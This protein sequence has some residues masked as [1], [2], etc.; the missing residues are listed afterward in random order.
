MKKRL[1][2]SIPSEIKVG[3][4]VIEL[5]I[6]D[7][8]FLGLGK[9]AVRGT[10]LRSA[11]VPLRPEIQTPDGIR[12]DAFRLDAVRYQRGAVVLLTTAFGRQ[13]MFG[14]YRDEYDSLLA[15][16]RTEGGPFA[17]V[18]EWRLRPETLTLDDTAY[19]GFSYSLRFR[20]KKRSIHQVLMVATWELGGRA[21]GNTLLNQ[22]QVNPPVYT[23]KQSTA[24]T[25]ACWRQLGE[26]GKPDGYSFQFSSRYSPIQCFDFQYGSAG[27]LFG[28][29]PDFVDA[30]S[31]M[32]KNPGEDVVFVLDKYLMPLSRDVAF[33]RKCILWA[34]PPAEGVKEHLMHDR[35]LRAFDHAQGRVRAAFKIQTPYILPETGLLY[36]TSLDAK[37]KLV[38][39]VAGKPYAPR[40]TLAAWAKHL[41]ALAA[42]GVRRLIPEV[43][44]ESD[45]TENGY[46]YK[47]QNGIHGDLATSSVCNVWRYQVAEFWGG[48]KAW[49]EFYRAGKASGLEIGHWV[50]SQL[51][52]NGPVI[53]EHPEFICQA[54]NTRPHAGGGLINITFGL[55]WD[56]AC[57]WM[58]EQFAEWKRHGLDYI[59]FDSIGNYGF[60][61]VDYKAR[62]Q[63]NA[64]GLARF[65][66]GLNRMGIKAITVE[67]VSPMG[68]GRS[69]MSDNMTEKKRA[70]DAVAGQNDWS[71]WVGHEDML[72]NTT[73]SV[74][75]HPSR[76]QRE[77]REQIFRALANRSLLMFGD[78]GEADAWPA[79]VER[80][81]LYYRTYNQ[82][83]RLMRQRR[84]LPGQQGVEW[85][86]KDGARA[87]FAY[88]AF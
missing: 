41:P 77:L 40:D 33:P 26:V 42:A 13:G 21:S 19:E 53:R 49:E 51:S 47:L 25:T 30:H 46:T 80:M 22:G 8:R 35:W 86:G 74:Q 85:R 45:V 39:W 58:L 4:A 3:Q 50:G 2:S 55:N 88:T 75:P 37:G 9:I 87:L 14:E 78:F 11:T 54:A 27:T 72:V 1:A 68:I 32:Q 83:G 15:W 6:E 38:M 57:D 7:R 60:M 17:D 18:V 28:Y 24:F 71:W 10:P 76:S 70:S 36:R 66:G 59:F 79:N 34:P 81:A 44:A 20:S 82:L 52:P 29:W 69:G 16:P 48:W 67:G 65:I 12:Y 64:A 31:L 84:L 63:P 43:V 61:G 56:R 23:C 62:M 5:L 73:F